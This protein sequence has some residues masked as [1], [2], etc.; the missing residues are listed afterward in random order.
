MG[1]LHLIRHGQASFGTRDYDRLSELGFAQSEH[2]GRWLSFTGAKAGRI[3]TGSMRR[4]RQTA[5]ACLTVWGIEADIV[6]D[7]AFDEFDHQEV[8]L[9]AH[10]EFA[11]PDRL[12]ALVAEP[13]GK[14]AFQAVFSESVERWISGRHPADYSQSWNEFRARCV[15]GLMR[16]AEHED[17]WIF[18][19]GGPIAAITQTVLGVP[20]DRVLDLNWSIKNSSVS[21]I[22]HRNGRLRLG[23][24][25]S[26]AHLAVIKDGGLATYR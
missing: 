22:L 2:L 14:R 9:R 21:Q 24:F 20:D 16:A 15:E 7:R 8:L 11:E 10:P 26:I 1:A 18:T 19:S 25:N 4:H 12:E 5:Y 3:I 17:V 23:H 6:E 13:D